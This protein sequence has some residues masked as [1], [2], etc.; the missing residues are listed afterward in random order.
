MKIPFLIFLFFVFSQGFGQTK[1]QFDRLDQVKGLANRSVTS[2]VQDP[3]GFIWFGTPDGLIRYDGYEIK[4]YKNN[5]KDKNSLG[6]NNIRGLAKDKEGNLWIATQ[7]AGLDKYDVRT[8]QFTHFRHS[9][10]E[11]TSL[12]GNAVWSVFV[13]SKGMIWAGTWS[14]GLNRLDPLT[15][16]VSR[17]EEKNYVPVLAIAEDKECT[18]S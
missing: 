1:L 10:D 18:I 14:D 6:D 16:K 15:N 7:G 3:L 9:A 11:P 2:I 5:L 13:D 17:I 4:L 12:S 8:E